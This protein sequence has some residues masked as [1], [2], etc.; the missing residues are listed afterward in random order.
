MSRDT[1]HG[2][3]G[4][5]LMAAFREGTERQRRFA[6]VLDEAITEVTGLLI[7]GEQISFSKH[8]P[9]Y[10]ALP[11]TLEVV[12]ST[13]ETEGVI[14]GVELRTALGVPV[15]IV[16]T[17]DNVPALGLVGTSTVDGALQF[18]RLG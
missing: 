17:S 18:R 12:G 13:G 10:T 3:A 11:G 14:T 1:V 8:L 2:L 5:T 16:T 7:A 4:A 9:P 6:L 15:L